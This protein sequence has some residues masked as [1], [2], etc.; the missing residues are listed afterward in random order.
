M[1]QRTRSTKPQRTTSGLSR[2]AFLKSTGVG[3]RRR[4]RRDRA[5]PAHQRGGAGDAEHLVGLP[6][7]RAVLQEGR[8]GVRQDA[9]RLQARDALE[10]TSASMEQKITAAIPTETGPDLFD[11]SR[12]IILSLADANFVPPDPPKVMALLKSN[13]FHP[14]GRRVQHVEGA[15]VRRPVPRGLEAGALLQHE[16][17]QGGRAR[18]EQAAGDLRRAH[19]LRAEA[20]EAGR[21]GQPDA[22]GH[23][24]P[25]G[26][27]GLGRRREVLVRA[28][29]HGWRSGHPDQVG[30]VAQQLRQRRR[31]RGA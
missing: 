2:R 28:L 16:D 17:V 1:K 14:V 7:D 18:S 26:G 23:H 25:A 15:G 10:P 3:P 30:Q 20:H 31:A 12:N 8:R 11:V 19:D 22:R 4:G 6:R 5:Q 24:A 21:R 9:S 13:A 29:R 27:P